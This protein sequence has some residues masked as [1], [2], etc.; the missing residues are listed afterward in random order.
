[1]PVISKEISNSSSRR[2]FCLVLG[3]FCLLVCWVFF[4][5]PTRLHTGPLVQPHRGQFCESR[6]EDCNE[7]TV[8]SIIKYGIY[9]FPGMIGTLLP[10][11]K[12]GFYLFSCTQKSPHTQC[13]ACAELLPE[14]FQNLFSLDYLCLQPPAGL[15]QSRYIQH[16]IPLSY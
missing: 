13:T 5:L 6:G 11:T 8:P 3:C 4:G 16:I 12:R 1:M 7:F 2:A 15:C 10:Q 14:I 9:S